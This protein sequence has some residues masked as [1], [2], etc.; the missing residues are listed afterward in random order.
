M[1]IHG[2]LRS[3]RVSVEQEPG[4]ILQVPAEKGPDRSRDPGPCPAQRFL[5]LHVWLQS[6]RATHVANQKR[7]MSG[8]TALVVRI[9][10][11]SVENF[12]L[13]NRSCPDTNLFKA[14]VVESRV[15][16]SWIRR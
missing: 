16:R 3:G 5:F 2:L 12:S 7:G 11:K 6:F 8:G 1:L 9:Y 15:A 4:F 10:D 14:D 13:R